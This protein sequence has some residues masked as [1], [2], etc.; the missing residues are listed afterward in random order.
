M[1]V[2]GGDS[3]ENPQHNA[4][5]PEQQ[6]WSQPEP[7]TPEDLPYPPSSGFAGPSGPPPPGYPPPAY[8][9]PGDYLPPAYS[10]PRDYPPP[11]AYPPPGGY[12]PAEYPNA[13]GYGG[14]PYPPPLPPGGPA[15]G[16]GPPPVGGY[17]VPGYLTGYGQQSRTNPLAIASLIS[18]CLGLLCCGISAIVGVV[19][20]VVALS[21]IKQSREEGYGLA[22]AGIVIGLAVMLIFLFAAMV[23]L[24]TR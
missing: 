9:P 5:R 21:Q 23:K 4:D 12:P 6:T 15:G 16:Y 8:P 19:L 22:V 11:P 3:G 24:Q 2:P 14:P 20:G 1:T 17:P 18:S 13:P 7:R 10:P